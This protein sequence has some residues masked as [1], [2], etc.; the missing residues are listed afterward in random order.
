MRFNSDTAANYTVHN[1]YGA[2]SSVSSEGAANLDRAYI[3]IA[4][5]AGAAAN[6]YSG[7]VIDLLD[8]ASTVKFKTARSLAGLHATS[9]F[10]YLKSTLWRST[11]AITTIQLLPDVGT[12]IV[13]GSRFSL[14]GIRG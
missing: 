6:I 5:G 13:A 3:S 12:A 14:Y 8:F 10:I 4:S 2:G 1:L 7:S 9:R 11:S